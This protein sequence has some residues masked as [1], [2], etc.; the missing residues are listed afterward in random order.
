MSGRRNSAVGR[1]QRRHGFRF[2]F[3][4]FAFLG[5]GRNVVRKKLDRNGAFEFGED[6]IVENGFADHDQLQHSNFSVDIEIFFRKVSRLTFQGKPMENNL[7]LGILLVIAFG[8][9]AFLTREKK[10]KEA[11]VFTRKLLHEDMLELRVL[12]RP[13]I[14]TL[15]FTRQ[16]KRDVCIA[17]WRVHLPAAAGDDDVLLAFVFIRCTNS[18]LHR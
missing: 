11:L 9:V 12:L 10:T 15:H 17:G 4:T 14:F 18:G 1:V 16:R 8:V 5:T 2:D 7:L 3:K 6:F 13:S